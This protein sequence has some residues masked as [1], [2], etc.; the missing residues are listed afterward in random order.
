[1]ARWRL[2][3]AAACALA[4]IE[5]LAVR[6]P[7]ATA[8]RLAP[9][10]SAVGRRTPLAALA[11]GAAAAAEEPQIAAAA[12]KPKPR[13]KAKPKPK[14]DAAAA[15]GDEAGTDLEIVTLEELRELKANGN[16]R[17]GVK[18]VTEAMFRRQDATLKKIKPET[19]SP[20]EAAR[21]KAR[22]Q[23]AT[24]ARDRTGFLFR[25]SEG[26]YDVPFI[27]EPRWFWL[28]TRKN[29]ER[30]VCEALKQIGAS[31]PRFRDKILDA[32]HPESVTIKMKGASG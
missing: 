2:L 18:Y 28:Q 30:K 12:A 13:A 7:S 8:A 11:P 22:R 17:P 6:R 14:K 24:S 29:S 16:L 10:Q 26:E 4:C 32:Y 20:E 3:L 23:A 21:E 19:K 27:D 1:M 25:D 31:Q 5:A 15:A 9:H